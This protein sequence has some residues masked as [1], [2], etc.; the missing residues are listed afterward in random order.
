MLQCNAIKIK[1]CD[2]ERKLKAVERTKLTILISD[3][4][5]NMTIMILVLIIMKI[6]MLLQMIKLHKQCL[7]WLVM[8]SDLLSWYKRC[9]IANILRN[10]TDLLVN[11]QPI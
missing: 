8:L 2:E 5:K 10:T 7:S 1:L 4:T 3:N 9:V 11:C 6:M